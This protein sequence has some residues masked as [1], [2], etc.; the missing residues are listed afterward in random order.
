LLNPMK[1]AIIMD[2]KYKVNETSRDLKSW[3]EI[4]NRTIKKIG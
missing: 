1:P 2:S 4:K 3:Y